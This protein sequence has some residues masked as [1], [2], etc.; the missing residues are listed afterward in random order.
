M[1]YPAWRRV[2]GSSSTPISRA[3]SAA[4]DG[5]GMGNSRDWSGVHT[6][7][8]ISMASKPWMVRSVPPAMR[9]LERV[10]M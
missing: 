10:S 6:C 2:R 7:S 9:S 5:M 3:I 1:R 4:A 8:A